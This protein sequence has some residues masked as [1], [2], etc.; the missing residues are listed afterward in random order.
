MRISRIKRNTYGGLAATFA[1]FST[2]AAAYL[3]PIQFLP[4]PAPPPSEARGNLQE[5]AKIFKK[6]LVYKKEYTDNST[7]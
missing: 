7:L 3:H 6:K 1:T 5:R 4:H 2:F